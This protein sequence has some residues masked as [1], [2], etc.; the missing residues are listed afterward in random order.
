MILFWR[1]SN[2]VEKILQKISENIPCDII[3]ENFENVEKILQKIS[4]NIS[5]NFENYFGKLREIFRK[6]LKNIT[7]VFEIF[8]KFR[9]LLRRILRI[10]KIFRKQFLE[11]FK[12]YYGVF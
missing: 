9:G 3:L 2:N 6:V 10:D 12:D 1:I 11:N 5:G 8:G 7:E 4:E